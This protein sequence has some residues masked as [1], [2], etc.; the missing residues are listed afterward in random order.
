LKNA[1][2]VFYQITEKELIRDD[3]TNISKLLEKL[4]I[5]EEKAC[6]CLHLSFYDIDFEREPIYL[7]KAK[8]NFIKAVYKKY[9]QLFYFLAGDPAKLEVFYCIVDVKLKNSLVV[10][11]YKIKMS[12]LIEKI[13]EDIC[14]YGVEIN[15]EWGASLS[16]KFLDLLKRR[17]FQVRHT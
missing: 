15:D 12:K 2:E 1:S 14:R 8:C 11:R 10:P 4:T 7:D 13:S 6:G 17:H 3:Y 16:I 9:N 5:N